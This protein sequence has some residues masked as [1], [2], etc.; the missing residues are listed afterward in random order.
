MRILRLDEIQ[1]ISGAK[2]SSGDA[3]GFDISLAMSSVVAGFGVGNLVG[4]YYG[5]QLLTRIGLG[6][7]LATGGAGVLAYY[8]GVVGM[9]ACLALHGNLLASFH[10]P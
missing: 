4:G 8:S 1:H 7:V 5:Y 2:I 10:M 6:T 3:F 9:Y